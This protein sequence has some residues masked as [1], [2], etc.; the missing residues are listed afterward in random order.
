MR[1]KL[2]KYLLSNFKFNYCQKLGNVAF[3]RNNRIFCI[4]FIFMV[5]KYFFHYLKRST[6]LHLVSGSG[7]VL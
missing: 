3:S 2:L 7:K 1:L 5:Y 6:N 4:T